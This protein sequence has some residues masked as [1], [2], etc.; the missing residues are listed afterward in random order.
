MAKW[1]M[2]HCGSSYFVLMIHIIFRDSFQNMMNFSF[3]FLPVYHPN[4]EEKGDPKLYA[5]NVRALMAR[6]VGIS[7][8]KGQNQLYAH[9][10]RA[11][12]ARYVGISRSKGQNQLYALTMSEP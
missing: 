3:Q 9:N 6:Y 1:L 7:R 2:I 8:S 11:P 5:H 4:E 10:V 12:M